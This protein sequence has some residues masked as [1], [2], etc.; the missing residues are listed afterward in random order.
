MARKRTMQ[1]FEEW[2]RHPENIEAFWARLE[3]D[4]KLTF[5]DACYSGRIPYMAMYRLV[6]DTPAILERY[7]GILKARAH[8]AIE[9]TVAIA[10][11]VKPEKDEVAKAKLQVETRQAAASY[12]DRERYG[13]RVQVDKSV[14]VHVDAGLVGLAGD[15]LKLASTREKVV[16]GQTLT[17]PVKDDAA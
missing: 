9:Q 13:Q 1:L 7:Q 14:S 12:W 5:R 16:E 6:H 2:S 3:A 10:D 17:L 11:E 4:E 15:L 8:Q